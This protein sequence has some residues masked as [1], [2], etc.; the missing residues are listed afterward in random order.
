M[1]CRV[2][3]EEERVSLHLQDVVK[4]R[5]LADFLLKE[6]VEPQMKLQEVEKG[7]EKPVVS[8]E[9]D[10]FVEVTREKKNTLKV[11]VQEEDA[12]RPQ[13]KKRKLE[14]QSSPTVGAEPMEVTEKEQ[15][16]PRRRQCF[17][18]QQ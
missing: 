13:V 10:A 3:D 1:E 9:E 15:K 14:S 4:L 6:K 2:E 12:T 18:C 17:R 16:A 7:F 11:T 5:D 8:K